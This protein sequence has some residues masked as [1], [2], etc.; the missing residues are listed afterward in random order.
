[1]LKLSCCY[2]FTYLK[3]SSVVGLKKK[4]FIFVLLLYLGD[5]FAVEA[6][7]GGDDGGVP[8]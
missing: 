1:M 4:S 2:Y 5:Y 3:Q 8:R 7:A 6:Y